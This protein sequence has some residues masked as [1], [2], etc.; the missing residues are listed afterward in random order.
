MLGW[1]E[2][3]LIFVIVIL[4]FGAGRLASVGRGLGEGIAN[5]RD[6]LNK[7]GR[8]DKALEEKKNQ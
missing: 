2:L 1:P 5:F 4:L 6:G 7:G 8:D 3:L